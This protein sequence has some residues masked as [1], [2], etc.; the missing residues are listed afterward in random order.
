MI[1]KSMEDFMAQAVSA[2][3]EKLKKK[4]SEA[5]AYLNNILDQVGDRWEMQVHSQ[6]GGWTVRQLVNHIATADRG[7]NNMVMNAAEGINIVP[8]DFD[9]EWYN[10]RTTEETT[11]KPAKLSREEMAQQ[12]A[13]LLEWLETVD[14][15]KLDREGRHATLR[16]MSVENLMRIMAIHERDHANEI[17]RAL[18]VGMKEDRVSHD[19][20][21]QV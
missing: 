11:D 9:L 18:D 2:R 3:K 8:E 21:N 12:R 6:E 7:H 19:A 13:E 16:L 1:S 10:R 4:L 15:E 17:A 14:E 20:S 5:R